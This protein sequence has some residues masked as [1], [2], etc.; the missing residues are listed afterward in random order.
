MFKCISPV[1]LQFEVT[2]RCNNR[3]LFCYNEKSIINQPQELDTRAAEKVISDIKES[4]VMSLNF[5]GGEPL[6]REDFF[7]LAEHAHSLGLDIHLNTNASLIDDFCAKNIARFFPSICTTILSG[8]PKIHD[9]LSGR[10][11]AQQDAIEGIKHLRRHSVYVSVN[12]MISNFNYSRI[13]ETLELL[14][15]LSIRS[16]LITRYVPNPDNPDNLYIADKNFFDAIR[17]V[18]EYNKKNQCFDRIALPQPIKLCEVPQDLHY[19]ILNWNIPCNIGLCTA[20]INAFGE[21]TPCNLVKTPV[22]GRL[23]QNSLLDVWAKFDGAGYCEKQ[24][25]TEQCLS[26]REL[27]YCGGGCKGFNMSNSLVKET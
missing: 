6:I 22:L 27:T 12:V 10:S 20:S 17:V 18:N 3:C 7:E 21:L 5:N 16:L 4:G 15:S 24:H 8:D 9:M 13:S 14:R 2:Y 25:L 26:C 23:T 19:V 11:G 1:N